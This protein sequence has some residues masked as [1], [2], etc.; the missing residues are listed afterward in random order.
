MIRQHHQPMDMSLSKLWEMVKDWQAWRAAIHGIAKS[1]TQLSDQTVTTEFSF[2]CL[3]NSSVIA[4][5]RR[6]RDRQD[7]EK[8]C[9]LELNQGK[10][11]KCKGK[12]VV[13]VQSLG[14]V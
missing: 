13:A 10:M 1:W 4:G 8:T 2:Q 14:R 9:L 11:E 3:K 6:K 7:C 12:M 5:Y